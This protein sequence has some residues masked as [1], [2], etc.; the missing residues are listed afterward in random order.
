MSAVTEKIVELV[1]ELEEHLNIALEEVLDDMDEKEEEHFLE[2][3]YDEF[4][5]SIIEKWEQA[6]VKGKTPL[7]VF[8]ELREEE[9]FTCMMRLNE[10]GQLWIPESLENVFAGFTGEFQGE[11]LAY[12][13]RVLPEEVMALGGV[14]ILL[15][16]ALCK[17]KSEK[18]LKLLIDFL[19]GI[20]FEPEEEDMPEELNM[21]HILSE[22]IKEFGESAVPL[23]IEKL[24]N[25]EEFTTGE[26]YLTA[27]LGII[28]RD[29][30]SQ[31]IYSILR[32]FFKNENYRGLGAMILADYG[33]MH[34]I[35]LIKT[36]LDSDLSDANQ[37]DVND[38]ILAVKQLGGD[39]SDY[40]QEV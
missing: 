12:L 36:W 32:D 23:L 17:A 35:A 19:S 20:Q 13:K 40:V 38:A 6:P 14:T 4:Q 27:I 8:Q 37:T 3:E 24:Q 25:K 16:D 29:N 2:T 34:A 39:I 31:E 1:Y 26:E 5:K 15:T 28:G 10:V 22:K 30:Q 9:A 33:D 7:E 11:A 21:Y 18:L